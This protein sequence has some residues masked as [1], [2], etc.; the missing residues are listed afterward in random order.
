M[1]SFRIRAAP[2]VFA[3]FTFLA[4]LSGVF[5]SEVYADHQTRIPKAISDAEKD[6]GVNGVPQDVIKHF[7][8]VGPVRVS[9]SALLEDE[10]YEERGSGF[11]I[12]DDLLL[13]AFHLF[14]PFEELLASK[15]LKIAVFIGG[16]T[17]YGHIPDSRYY[18]AEKDLA[19]VKLKEKI[20]IDPIPIA[21][22]DPEIG[23]KVYT[24]GFAIIDRPAALVPGYK[25]AAY[26]YGVRSLVT[27]R[28]FEHGY[29]GAP[30]FNERG[31]AIG[32]AE[33]I[34]PSGVFGYSVPWEY[35]LK[36]LDKIPKPVP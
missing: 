35:V 3:I 8:A 2:V 22:S 30:L 15:K 20:P 29:S 6:A 27:S 32:V 25:G 34:S 9:I 17:V 19:V 4:I 5:A 1:A 26:N 23:D 31:E 21:K 11:L 24:F 12:A 7:K 28:G 13:T 36:L 16:K 14:P 18:D 33:A 10:S